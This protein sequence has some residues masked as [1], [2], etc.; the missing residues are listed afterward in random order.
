LHLQV[1][2]FPKVSYKDRGMPSNLFEGLGS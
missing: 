2:G 1:I